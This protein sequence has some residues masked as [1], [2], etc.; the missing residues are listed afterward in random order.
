[1]LQSE[2]LMAPLSLVVIQR[3]AI[4]GG[5]YFLGAWFGVNYTITPGGIAVLWPPNAMLLA[6]FLL[7]PPR[8]WPWLALAALAAELVAD[9]PAFP[10]WAAISFGLINVFEVTLAGLLIRHLC[11]ERFTFGRL[12]EGRAFL[13]SGPLLA[14]ALA[15]ALGA[16]I[17]VILGRADGGYVGAWRTWWFGDALGLL[18]LTPVLVTATRWFEQNRWP[19]PSLRQLMEFLALAGLV[20]AM[21][22]LTFIQND[23]GALQFYFAPILLL[24]LGLWAALRFKV[25]VAA[26]IAALISLLAVSHLVA[27]IY[28]Y[29]QVSS[30]QAVWLTQE[31]LGIVVVVTVGL[32]ILMHEL[33]EQREQLL[34]QEL[35]LHAS[36]VRLEAVVDERTNELK[37]TNEKLHKA[38]QR[39]KALATTDF[40]TGFSNRRHFEELGQRQL[41]RVAAASESASLITFDLDRFKQVNDRYG[42]SM[43]DEVLRQLS[44]SVN[45]ELRP[46]DL[47]GRSG[48]EEF[49]ILLMQADSNQ[50]CQVAER[51]RLGIEALNI[52]HQSQVIRVTASFGVAEWN[53]HEALDTLMQKA[54]RALYRAKRLGRNRVEAEQRER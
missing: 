9:I 51:I 5:G 47:C 33:R 21:G 27:G 49:V 4:V 20:T 13:L 48:G 45:N 29:P 11:G 43:G 19:R 36:N 18:V 37:R 30:G 42:H 53:G 8:Q 24:P 23:P 6:A 12:H 15:A 34:V 40:L 32:A 50:A 26:L 16:T 25:H 14:S 17:Y 1:M 31:Y 28:P 2:Y 22:V 41:K 44:N 7:W 38:N 35:D 3:M 39:L 46:S 10:L 52:E 54:D